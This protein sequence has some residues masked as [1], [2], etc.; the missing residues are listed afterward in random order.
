MYLPGTETTLL[1]QLTR[2]SD[3]QHRLPGWG[4]VFVLRPKR[5]T[6]NTEQGAQ[7]KG[8][9]KGGSS[10]AVWGRWEQVE[11]RP[12]GQPGEMGSGRQEQEPEVKRMAEEMGLWCCHEERKSRRKAELRWE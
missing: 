3:Q 7:V 12:E 11:A 1:T 9:L 2:K 10:G 8:K 5:G 4:D 6:N